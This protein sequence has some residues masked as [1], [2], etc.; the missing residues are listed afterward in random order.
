MD[1]RIE[2]VV[3]LVELQTMLVATNPRFVGFGVRVVALAD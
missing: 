2:N 3:E 1:L